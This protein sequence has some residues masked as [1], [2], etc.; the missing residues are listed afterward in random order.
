V[1]FL[2]SELGAGALRVMASLKRTLDP[3]CR[4][5]EKFE[6]VVV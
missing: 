3:V 4:D 6:R 1:K 5:A 2:E